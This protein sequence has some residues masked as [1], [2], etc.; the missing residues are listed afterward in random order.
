M[1]VNPSIRRS[2]PAGVT[3]LELT[4][5]ILVLLSI[6]SVSFIGIKAW[7]RG[8]DRASCI[9]N[10]RNMQLALRS[11]S[12]MYQ[13]RPG[14]VDPSGNLVNALVGPD[15]HLTNPPKCPGRGE[16]ADL[17]NFVPQVGTLYMT[18]SLADSENHVP[19]FYGD[20]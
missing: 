20:W 16:Y 14:R 15:G 9:T 10:I 6:I 11:H 2:H 5:I 17:G 12:N 3:L 7:K 19:E 13:L 4:V 8:S 18:C 1:K